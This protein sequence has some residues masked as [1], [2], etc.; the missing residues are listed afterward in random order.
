M[1]VPKK[2]SHKPIISVNHYDKIDGLYAN[3]TD[4]KALSIGKA[5]YDNEEISLKVWRRDDNGWKRGSEE[6]PIH[7]N[8]D[9]SILF[10]SSLLTET[11]SKFPK[12]VLRE[13][14]VDIENMEIIKDYYENKKQFLKPRLQEL[15]RLLNDF[16][17]NKGH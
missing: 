7:R 5:Q 10:L 9:L 4:T 8:L 16:L 13:D 3:N 15:Q 12:S 11:S 1:E 6:L 14:I 2:L 17:E